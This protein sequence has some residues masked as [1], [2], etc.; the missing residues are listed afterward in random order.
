MESAGEQSHRGELV[1]QSLVIAGLS[2]RY[3][4]V[5]ALTGI[6]LAIEP[7]EFVTL[8]G[9]SGCGKTTLLKAIAG[10]APQDEGNVMLGGRQ[11]SDLPAYRRDIGIVFQN[12][13]L[14]PHYTVAE[15]VSF[16]LR[17]RK[18]GKAARRQRVA[19]VLR[20]VRLEGFDTR[21]PNQLSG[22]QQQRVAL[23]RSLAINP[24]LLL[25]D[26]PFGALDR[27]LRVEMQVELKLLLK[28]LG[29]TT[30]FVTHDQEEAM[31]LSDRIAVMDRGRI[32]QCADPKTIYDHP[33][34]AYV[35]DFIGITN[36]LPA[37]LIERGPAALMEVLTLRLSLPF[38]ADGPEPRRLLAVRPEN[39]I[40]TRAEEDRNGTGWAGRVALASHTGPRLD[41]DVILADGTRLKVSV[42]RETS[43]PELAVGSSVRVRIANP[44]RCRL[45]PA[46]EEAF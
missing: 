28:P 9:P 7:G 10:F 26:E 39:L 22:G 13:A 31:C 12:Y 34:S 35:A 42:S 6:N 15:N 38:A 45:L 40:L 17:M 8:L 27:K 3:G 37:R 11:L 32:I 14:F 18:F 5:A 23:A 25:L 1:G 43:E 46:H 33:A 2:K 19:E 44:A 30:L 29:I 16:G 24:Q 41:Y 36:L 4:D 20:L 21:Y